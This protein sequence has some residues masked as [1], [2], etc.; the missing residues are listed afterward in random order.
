MK[1]LVMG[2]GLEEVELNVL[3]LDARK[4]VFGVCE[5]HRRRPAWLYTQSRF[6]AMVSSLIAR[7]S[8]RP[9]TQ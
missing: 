9:E 4:S 8:I 5:Q 6:T 7:R 1:Q 2:D 3:G